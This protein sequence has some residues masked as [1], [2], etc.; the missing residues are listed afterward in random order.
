MLDGDLV[1][2][3][4]QDGVGGVKL[5]V[6]RIGPAA[7]TRLSTI[8]LDAADRWF[9]DVAVSGATVA[10]GLQAGGLAVVDATNPSAPVRLAQAAPV[11]H[12]G[13][14]AFAGSVL[15][16]NAIDGAT[17][18]RSFDAADPAALVALGASSPRV[19]PQANDVGPLRWGGGLLFASLFYADG[20]LF[21][22]L[23][24]AAPALA[25]GPV[26]Q[27]RLYGTQVTFGDTFVLLGSAENVTR[28]DFD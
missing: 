11:A 18:V 28:I 1:Y 3:S 10:V 19:N 25:G 26:D 27:L 6:L 13:G 21:D 17:N 15:F 8:G 22:A 23:D 24:P 20:A 9:P 2:L 4:T 12:A 16:V 5:H 14:V 7:I